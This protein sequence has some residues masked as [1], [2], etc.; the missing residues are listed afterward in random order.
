MS[1]TLCQIESLLPQTQCRQCGYDGCAPYAA[2][3]AAGQADINLC[4]PGGDTVMRDLA[5]LL[6]REA[7]QLLQA[8]KA[9]APKVLALIDEAACIGC[10]ACIKACPVDAIMGATKYMHT[11]LADEC[12]GCELCLPPCPVDCIQFIPSGEAWLPKAHYL[13]DQQLNQRSAAARHAQ[14]RHQRRTERLGREAAARQKHLARRAKASAQAERVQPAKAELD[15]AQRI[16]QAMARAQAQQNQRTTPENQT[17]FAQQQI[18]KAQHRAAFRRAQ[19]DVK[20]GTEA[21]KQAALVFLREY[22]AA[23]EAAEA[24]KINSQLPKSAN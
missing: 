16:A 8:A 18:I 21:E 17:S 10:A 23:Q 9:N 14:I 11:V 5:Q 7:K 2:A 24:E 1:I 4:P 12:V 13:A 15:P 19:R 22:K 6:D 3:L 20:H